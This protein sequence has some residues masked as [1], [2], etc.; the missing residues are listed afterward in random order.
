MFLKVTKNYHKPIAMVRSSHKLNFK[1]K[2]HHDAITNEITTS[3]K[4]ILQI[5]P[6]TPI[7]HKYKSKSI[8]YTSLNVPK[9]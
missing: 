8:K 6:N 1:I 7:Y 5:Y 2:I 9:N 4:L 3:F